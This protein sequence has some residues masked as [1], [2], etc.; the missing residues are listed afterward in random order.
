MLIHTPHGSK[1][2]LRNK[3]VS[4]CAIEVHLKGLLNGLLNVIIF[5]SALF[6]TAFMIVIH[7]L[8]HFIVHV[9]IY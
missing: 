7:P 4:N 5:I 3:L 1:I 2:D 6:F 8:K 9:S